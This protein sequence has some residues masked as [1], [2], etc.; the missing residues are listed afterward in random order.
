MCTAC[1]LDIFGVDTPTNSTAGIKAFQELANA[2]I[3]GTSD[4]KK[5]QSGHYGVWRV[6]L[7]TQKTCVHALRPSNKLRGFSERSSECAAGKNQKR[8]NA[9]RRNCIFAV[10]ES[11]SG[12]DVKKERHRR[13]LGGFI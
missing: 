12:V 9:L 2:C 13:H 8:Q 10:V 7:Y 6:A 1:L 11:A 3:E 4:P 5:L